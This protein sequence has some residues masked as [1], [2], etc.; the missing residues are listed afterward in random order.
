MSKTMQKGFTLIELMIV[1][2]IIG[3]LAAVALPQYQTYTAKSQLAAAL[4]EIVPAKTQFETLI[5]DGKATTAVADVG[6][7]SPTQRCTITVASFA[8]G[9]AGVMCTLVNSSSDVTTKVIVLVR[10]TGS[11][12]T[13]SCYSTADDKYLPSGCTKDT[14][15]AILPTA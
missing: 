11:T 8:T 15:K 14:A 6:L 7:T 9:T 10:A 13:W 5:A 3:I 12:G 4:S 1:V 2:A